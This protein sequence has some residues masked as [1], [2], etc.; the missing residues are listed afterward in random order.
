[1]SCR[2]PSG[3]VT[4][5]R[6][7]IAREGQRRGAPVLS[8]GTQI[9][10]AG[11]RE[12]AGEGEPGRAWIGVLWKLGGALRRACFN[13]NQR[14]GSSWD[15]ALRLRYSRRHAS[16][17]ARYCGWTT[18]AP[19][20]K[21]ARAVDRAA[22]KGRAVIRFPRGTPTPSVDLGDT[23]LGGKSSRTRRPPEKCSAT[24]ST[25]CLYRLSALARA[26]RLPSSG[27][28]GVWANQGRTNTADASDKSSRSRWWR[29][30]ARPMRSM[31]QSDGQIPTPVCS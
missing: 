15:H 31:R 19:L 6:Y 17:S 25:N 27:M 30:A 7:R 9:D 18:F 3:Q 24:C 21:G 1:M 5:P 10:P 12:V 2:W 28:V 16:K 4:L 13:R 26:D 22:R 29:A 8:L 20:G 14:T 11:P 23:T